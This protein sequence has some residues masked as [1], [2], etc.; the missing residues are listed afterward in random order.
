MALRLFPGKIT[1]QHRRCRGVL[2]QEYVGILYVVTDDVCAADCQT[3]G[4]NG[5]G[6]SMSSPVQRGRLIGCDATGRRGEL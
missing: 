6:R 4:N 2:V 5:L 3:I 1:A